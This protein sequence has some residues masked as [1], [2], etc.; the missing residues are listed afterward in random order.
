MALQ[1]IETVHLGNRT[2]ESISAAIVAGE[3]RPGEAY[4]DRSLG[5]L[6][7]V[8]RTPVREALHR[9]EAVGLVEP[10]GRHGW[11]VA[12][13]TEHDVR[14]LFEL[15]RALEPLGI[16]HLAASGD[17]KAERELGRFFETFAEPIPSARYST[18]FKR[19]AAFHKRIVEASGNQR[20]I[21]MY[22]VLEAHIDRGRHF[23]SLSAAGRVDA[24]LH[25]HVA[26]TDAIAARDFGAAR[27]ELIHH[28]EMGEQLMVDRV[29]EVAAGNEGA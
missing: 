4:S 28:L 1:R 16:D 5:E 24:T 22:G 20:L 2:F 25:E 7:G 11:V 3:M 27:A 8:S 29:R 18:Y 26:I 14:E 12:A 9:L 17:A 19:D 6:L 15:R 21:R 13:F 10:R 23:L